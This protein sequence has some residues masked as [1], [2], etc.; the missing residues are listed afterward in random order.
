VPGPAFAETWP[1]LRVYDGDT[2]YVQIPGLPPEL[3]EVGIRIRGIDTPEIGGKA[4][5]SWERRRGAAARARL[6]ELLRGS[7]E[8]GDLA[9]D[10]YGGRIDATV[11]VSGMDVAAILIREGFARPYTGG[12]RRGWC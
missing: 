5:C 10:K 2:F 12:K 9:W 6:T 4:K 3:R 7:I 8:Y 11:T 1:V